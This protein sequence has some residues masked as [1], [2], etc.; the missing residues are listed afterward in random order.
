M[1]TDHHELA[2]AMNSIRLR[3]DVLHGEFNLK[4]PDLDTLYSHTDKLLKAIGLAR[5]IE[6]SHARRTAA[7]GAHH[8]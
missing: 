1:T 8:D 3:M 5:I 6:A 7:G 2:E 4:N